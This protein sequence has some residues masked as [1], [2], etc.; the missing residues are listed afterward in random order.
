MHSIEA[1]LAGAGG[2][3]S[4]WVEKA[5]WHVHFGTHDD[6]VDRIRSVSY[7]AALPPRDQRA[8][9]GEIRAILREHQETSNSETVGIPYR[10]DAMYSERLRRQ[11][12]P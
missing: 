3:W 2:S 10:V 11:R 5:F 6:V 4:P 12:P 9:L 1:Y 7:V 8:V